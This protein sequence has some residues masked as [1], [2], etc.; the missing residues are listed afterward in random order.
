MKDF[1]FFILDKNKLLIL[2]SEHNPMIVLHTAKSQTDTAYDV[3]RR[4]KGH[5]LG[6]SSPNDFPW[7][8]LEN[9]NS[10]RIDDSDDFWCESGHSKIVRSSFSFVFLGPLDPPQRWTIPFLIHCWQHQTNTMSLRP[11]SWPIRLFERPASLRPLSLSENCLN[12]L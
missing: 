4:L 10:H 9:G 12:Y 6:Q 5:Q 1:L 8:N 2:F 3:G 7:H 11:R